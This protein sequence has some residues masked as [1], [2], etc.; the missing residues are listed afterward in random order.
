[1]EVLIPGKTLIGF[2]DSDNLEWGIVSH[3]EAR[4]LFVKVSYSL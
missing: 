2:A 1:M 4:E 3:D